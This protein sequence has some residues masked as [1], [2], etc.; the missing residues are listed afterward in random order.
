M[1]YQ[2]E[3]EKVLRFGD[4]LRGY[5]SSIPNVKGPISKAQNQNND[6]TIDISHP[7]FSVVITP[8]CS[9]GEKMISLTPLIKLKS[10]FYSNP[11]FVED[12]TRIN[13]K[14]DPKQATPPEEW[15]K[16]SP[17]EQ[18]R[19]LEESNTY[20]L[21]EFF[22]YEKHDIFPK[23]TIDSKKLGKFETYYYMIDFR[24]IYRLNCDAIL[25]PIQ[26]PLEAKCLQL[27]VKTRSELRGKIA[28][29]YSRTPKE[30]YILQEV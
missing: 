26:A 17:G 12:M 23:Y 24:N 18:T 14:M 6:Y 3:L 13:L 16:L 15:V 21:V 25:N 8:C 19:R 4:V 22:V 28:S 30:D 7:Q 5:I 29:Y 9:I 2:K 1:F 11:Y 10:K 20:A 27:S